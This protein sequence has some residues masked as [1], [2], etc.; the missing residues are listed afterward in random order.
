MMGPEDL[1][2]DRKD[3]YVWG[4]EEDDEPEILYSPEEEEDQE[5]E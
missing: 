1:D 5:A 2:L 4:E 3:R